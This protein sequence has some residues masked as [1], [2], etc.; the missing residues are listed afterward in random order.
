MTKQWLVY[1]LGRPG[2]TKVGYTCNLTARITQIQNGNASRLTLYATYAMESQQ[3]ARHLERWAHY[4]LLPFH[5]VGEWFLTSEQKARNVIH[6][7]LG[8]DFALIQNEWRQVGQLAEPPVILVAEAARQQWQDPTYR[9]RTLTVLK[10][11]AHRG[12][13]R[14]AHVNRQRWQDPGYREEMR[15]AQRQNWRDPAFRKRKTEAARQQMKQSWQ[16]PEYRKKI[17]EGQ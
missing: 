9:E 8:R 1:V 12:A 6:Y 4:L 14:A 17:A 11:S 5:G 7:L 2:E 15:E 16:D 3:A 13:E 10:A